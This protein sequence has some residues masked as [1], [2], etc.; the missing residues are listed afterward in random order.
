MTNFLFFLD[1]I[2]ALIFFIC[3]FCN[4]LAINFFPKCPTG[5]T[6]PSQYHL[7]TVNTNGSDHP[8]L[9]VFFPLPQPPASCPSVD[10]LLL[11]PPTWLLG[12]GLTFSPFLFAESHVSQCFD[13][14][15][16][17]GETHLQ[18]LPKKRKM[19]DQFFQVFIYSFI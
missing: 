5:V 16:N 2:I 17:F 4:V 15:A 14:L 3:L 18:Y 1:C 19:V 7:L 9:P 12:L 8:F 6:N 10:W 13:L 11:E